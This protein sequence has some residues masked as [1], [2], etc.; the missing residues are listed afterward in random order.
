MITCADVDQFRGKPLH[1]GKLRNLEPNIEAIEESTAKLTTLLEVLKKYKYGYACIL[2][3]LRA[4]RLGFLER[5]VFVFNTYAVM[6]ID[7]EL[8]GRQYSCSTA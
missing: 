2:K 5:K 7:A 3:V 1:T 8:V 6:C 4:R